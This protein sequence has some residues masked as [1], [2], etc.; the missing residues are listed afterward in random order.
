MDV[1]LGKH[2]VVLEFAFAQRRSVAGDDD[3]LG[4]ARSETFEGR[5]VAESDLPRFHDYAAVKSQQ[6]LRFI[7]LISKEQK[8]GYGKRTKRQ[9][10]VDTVSSLLCFLW[11]HRCAL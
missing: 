2:R 11:C 5:L 10:G 9:A 8:R 7:R 3:Q 4:F 6:W 1:R